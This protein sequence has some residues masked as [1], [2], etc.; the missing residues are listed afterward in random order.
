LFNQ[1]YN[2][3]NEELKEALLF[4]QKMHLQHFE[5]GML[6][7]INIKNKKSLKLIKTNALLLINKFNEK[8][9][10]II[11]KNKYFLNNKIVILNDVDIQQISKWEK[12]FKN[13][14]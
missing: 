7:Q 9:P 4:S 6:G 10:N 12:I 13:F 5:A 8:N 3:N 1:L 11:N 2:N 14:T